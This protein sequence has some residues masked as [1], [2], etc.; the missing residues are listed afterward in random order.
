MRQDARLIRIV[1]AAALAALLVAACA[2]RE[3][4]VL[5]PKADGSTGA[6]GAS[7]HGG[8]EVVLDAPYAQARTGLAGG[9]HHGTST[10]AAV[11]K[12]FGAA[13]G[14]M[15][16]APQ[17]STLYF[18]TG[19]DDVSPESTAALATMLEEMARRPSPEV[20][21]IGHTDGTGN[22][23]DNDALSL[24][25]AARVKQM[26]VGRGVPAGRIDTAGR[27]WREPLV[28]AA[29]GAEEPRNRRVEVRVR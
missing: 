21:V 9:L 24:Q 16:P 7:R 2:T 4:I 20:S 28:K 27:G 29:A 23:A 15:P 11:E 26:L 5:L 6:I 22:A 14:A 17:S 10:P 25:R 8:H 18:M 13:L 19:G 12:R 1:L 3:T